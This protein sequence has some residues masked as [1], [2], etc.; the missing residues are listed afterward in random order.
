MVTYNGISSTGTVVFNPITVEDESYPATGTGTLTADFDNDPSNPDETIDFT[1]TVNSV[2]SDGE[3][4]YNFALDEVIVPVAVL[5][6]DE[7]QLPAGGPDPVQT[8]SFIDGPDFVFFAVDASTASTSDI[9]EPILLTIPPAAGSPNSPI[10][11]G[12]PDLTEA[13]L[14]ALSA[15]VNIEGTGVNGTGDFHFIRDEIE[16]N[17]STS[18][19]GV[20]NNVLQG[21][22][23]EGDQPGTIN[24]FVSGA[25]DESFVINPEPLASSVKVY[26]SKTAGGFEPPGSGATAAKTDYLYWNLYDELGNNSGPNLVEFSDVFDEEDPGG[27][28][29]HLWSFTIDI[30]DVT[31]DGDFIDAMQFTMGFG[32]IK[33]PKMEVI[34]RGNTPPNDILL[35]FQATLT[36]KDGDSATSDFAINLYGHENTNDPEFDYVLQGGTSGSSP[37]PEAFNALDE[38]DPNDYLIQEFDIT[39]DTLVLKNL[40][41]TYNLD[42]SS[43][44]GVGDPFNDSL[45]TSDTGPLSVIV[46]DAILATINIVG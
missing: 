19:I 14:Q 21:E 46:E 13:E 29:E 3:G 45:I 25:F 26:I 6:T 30:D 34:V 10:G 2:N 23:L 27:T 15:M 5:S 44:Q 43:D 11:V 31:I 28:G 17:V 7:G 38:A 42:T 4:T 22:D 9:S 33:I 18:G 35:D 36:D 20:G 32:D 39:E 12:E 40:A 41:S 16:M 8:L 24:P 1:L 37:G